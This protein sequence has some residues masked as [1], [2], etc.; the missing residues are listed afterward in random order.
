MTIKKYIEKEVNDN[1]YFNTRE[2]KSVCVNTRIAKEIMYGN[3][4]FSKKFQS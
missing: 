2:K 4:R 1:K 3:E